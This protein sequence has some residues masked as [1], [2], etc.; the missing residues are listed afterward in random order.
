MQGAVGLI[1][2]GEGGG[3]RPGELRWHCVEHICCSPGTWLA[4]LCCDSSAGGGGGELL[5]GSLSLQQQ[6]N[7]MN[8]RSA[9]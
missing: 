7:H 5:K 8:K 6:A 2:L 9:R 4:F 1:G 3:S